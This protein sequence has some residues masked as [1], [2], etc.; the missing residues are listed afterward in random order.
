MSGK[1]RG[2][3]E[4]TVYQRKQGIDVRWEATIVVDGEKYCRYGKTHQEAL[5]KLG[6]LRRSLEQQTPL[7]DER[8]TVGEFLE[9]WFD[10][11]TRLRPGTA[12]RY[13]EYLVLHTIPTLGRMKLKL[14]SQPP[15]PGAALRRTSAGRGQFDQCASSACGHPGGAHFCGAPG[16]HLPQ[17]RAARGCAPNGAQ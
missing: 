3:G 15:A 6:E 7:G 5:R 17:S 2:H 8:Q 1:R 11:K 9:R 10:G 13:R 16:I 12:T 14:L 4:G